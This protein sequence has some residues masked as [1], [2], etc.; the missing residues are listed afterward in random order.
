MDNYYRKFVAILGIVIFSVLLHYIGV[1]RPI[2]NFLRHIID[3]LSRQIYTISIKV[4]D[5]EEQFASV[6]ELK[7]AYQKLKEENLSLNLDAARLAELESENH[8]LREALAFVTSS[9]FRHLGA[10]VIGKNSEPVGSALI[11]NRGAKDGVQQGNSVIVGQG[12]L[13]GSVITVEAESSVVRL[14]NDNES[15]I[16]VSIQNQEKS[17]GVVEGRHGVS[18]KLQLVPQNETITVGDVIMTSGLEEKIPRGLFVGKIQSVERE[19]YQPFQQA[20][21]NP[22]VDLEKITQVIVLIT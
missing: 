4:K 1:L 21:I 11:I 5:T 13:V 6:D 10:D 20:E 17:I 7:G 22:F 14:L 3:P 8:E 9:S 19:P 16:A 2:E 18:L 12:I 15:K